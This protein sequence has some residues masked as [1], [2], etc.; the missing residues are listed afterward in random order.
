MALDSG[1]RLLEWNSLIDLGFLW[2]GRDY[3]RTG[4]YFNR[5]LE[6]ARQIGDP[7]VL[8]H[9]LNR[10]GNW[11]MNTGRAEEGLDNAPGSAF[12]VPGARE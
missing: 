9:S 8:G 10:C 11:L 2:A 4:D 7:E 3:E 1:D 5:A 6:L 12:P